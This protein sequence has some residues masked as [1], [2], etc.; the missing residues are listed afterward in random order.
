MT[1]STR[2]NTP[3]TAGAPAPKRRRRTALVVTGVVVA[4]AVIAAVIGYNDNWGKP[5]PATPPAAASGGP[6]E[7]GGTVVSPA[8]GSGDNNGGGS[9]TAPAWKGVTFQDFH[10]AQLPISPLYGPQVYTDTH[11][12]GFAHNLGGAVEAAVHLGSRAS[13]QAGPDTYGPT[14]EQQMTG[15]TSTFRA[16]LD[17][18]YQEARQSSGVPDGTPLRIYAQVIGYAADG[19]DGSGQTVTLH[20]LSRGANPNTGGT[21]MGDFPM[22]LDWV[23]GDWKLRTPDGGQWP[24][25]PVSS[26]AGYTLFPGVNG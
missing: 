13:A 23:G 12:A 7:P 6:D 8:P 11:A 5:S 3:E 19:A 18:D 21:V 4:A 14:V 22:T 15:D 17:S 26:T 16:Q 2:N 25:N 10:G 20:L 1:N 24:F 9:S